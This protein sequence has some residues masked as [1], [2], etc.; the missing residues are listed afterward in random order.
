MERNEQT[1]IADN[2]SSLG[3]IKESMR[4]KITRILVGKWELKVLN[5]YSQSKSSIFCYKSKRRDILAG[6]MDGCYCCCW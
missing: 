2:V 1:K 6:A 4:P 3:Y 5:K